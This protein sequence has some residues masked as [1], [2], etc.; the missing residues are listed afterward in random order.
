[1]QEYEHTV[2][3]HETKCNPQGAFSLALD[4]GFRFLER[5]MTQSDAGTHLG[6][7][8]QERRNDPE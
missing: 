2:V 6:R 3:V 5:I 7:Q 8:M 1:M 4:A